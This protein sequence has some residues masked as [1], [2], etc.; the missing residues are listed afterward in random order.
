MR[1]F[2]RYLQANG[3]KVALVTDGR[4]SGASGKVLAAIHVTPE[5]AK[6]GVLSR[7]Q[8]GDLI[9]IDAREDLFHL[10]VTSE[11]LALRSDAQVPITRRWAMVCSYLLHN[12]VGL[13][14]QIRVPAF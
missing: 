6:G 4:L 12:V 2:C 13:G 8:D 9:E 10:H 11:Q 3:Q 7:I 5:A 1:S 14:L